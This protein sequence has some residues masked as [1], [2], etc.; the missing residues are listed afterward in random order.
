MQPCH[1][2]I[3]RVGAARS[4]PQY[5]AL[6]EIAD[7]P[8]SSDNV[9][10]QSALACIM[11]KSNERKRPNSNSYSGDRPGALSRAGLLEA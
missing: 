10:F 6:S 2:G 7:W 3:V 11:I 8:G 9:D 1:C 4:D 5:A